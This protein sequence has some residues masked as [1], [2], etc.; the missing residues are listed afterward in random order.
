VKVVKSDLAKVDRNDYLRKG[1]SMEIRKGTEAIGGAY[2]PGMHDPWK[3]HA[4]QMEFHKRL[5]SEGQVR[6]SG[7]FTTIGTVLTI[8]AAAVFLGV[9]AWQKWGKRDA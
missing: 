6:S 5:Q 4:Q 9:G 8:C 7:Q 1:A 3:L 2:S